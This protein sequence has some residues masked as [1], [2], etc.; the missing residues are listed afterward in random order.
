VLEGKL[1]HLGAKVKQLCSRGPKARGVGGAGG[2]AGE[3]GPGRGGRRERPPS[4]QPGE[5]AAAALGRG[6]RVG[7]GFGCPAPSGTPAGGRRVRARA[8]SAFYAFAFPNLN[9]RGL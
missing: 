3:G 6:P 5:W 1:R 9:G 7:L 2:R 4:R 8:P